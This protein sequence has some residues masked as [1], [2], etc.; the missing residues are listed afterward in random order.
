MSLKF[1]LPQYKP[2]ENDVHISSSVNREQE[3]NQYQKINITEK[4][5]I[6]STRILSRL[7]KNSKK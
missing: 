3:T 6:A 7:N 4:Q 2:I 5:I 1:E